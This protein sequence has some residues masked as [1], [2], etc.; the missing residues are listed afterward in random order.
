[1]G[2]TDRDGTVDFLI[3]SAW[4][5]IKG[6]H[7]G[8]VLLISSGVQKNKKTNE[9]SCGTPGRLRLAACRAREAP[10]AAAANPYETKLQPLIEDFLR[11]QEIPGFAI[12]VIDDG[13]V[14]Y[15]KGFGVLS[16]KGKD[17]DDAAIPLPH[18][19]D[20]EA[21][22]RHGR[23]AARREGPHVPRRADHDVPALFRDRGSARED[24]HRPADAHAHLRDAR[25]R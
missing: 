8:R 9:A 13:K 14:V 11:K 16:L 1:M 25:R 12:A 4:S 24:D 17:A 3:T 22:R 7:S 18:G 2:D 6:N 10:K 23:D 20:H 21:L 19:V 15:E 5:G